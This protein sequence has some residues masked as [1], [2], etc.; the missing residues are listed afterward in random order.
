MCQKCNGSTMPFGVNPFS[1]KNSISIF[2]LDAICTPKKK[3]K[4]NGVFQCLFCMSPVII[5]HRKSSTGEKE[6]RL[7]KIIIAAPAR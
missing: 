2:N 7:T 3:Q 6:F 1:C 4:K 5:G